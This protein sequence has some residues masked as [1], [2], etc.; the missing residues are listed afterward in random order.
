VTGVPNAEAQR[1]PR[2]A[3][4]ISDWKFEISKKNKDKNKTSPEELQ[5]GQIIGVFKQIPPSAPD[6]KFCGG[7]RGGTPRNV[8]QLRAYS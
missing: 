7:S 6:D 3:K 4:A 5:V 1:T 2:K 8:L